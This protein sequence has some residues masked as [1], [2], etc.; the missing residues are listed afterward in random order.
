MDVGMDG[1]MDGQ[2]EAIPDDLNDGGTFTHAVQDIIGTRFV[3]FCPTT[4]QDN[5]TIIAGGESTRTIVHG[6][7]AFKLSTQDGHDCLSPWF[8]HTLLGRQTTHPLTILEMLR[9]H[10]HQHRCH[11]ISQS[12]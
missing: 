5:Q 8:Q 10:Q 3:L 1:E 11:G 7:I 6:R 2:W 9:Q 4:F 12:K